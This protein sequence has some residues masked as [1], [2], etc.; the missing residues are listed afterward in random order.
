MCEEHTPQCKACML[1]VLGIIL[2][3]VRLYTAW[4]IW[5]V[6]GAIL[7]VKGIIKLIMPN[8][9]CQTKASKKK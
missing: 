4:D 7:I 2:V 1:I 6:I 3:L 5:L 9:Y 8:C